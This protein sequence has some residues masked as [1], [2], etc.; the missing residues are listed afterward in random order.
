[1]VSIDPA[2]VMWS[3]PE[4]ERADRPLLVLLHGYGSYEGD[5]FGLSPHLPLSPVIASVR[6]PFAEGNGYSWFPLSGDDRLDVATASAQAVLDW[7]DTLSFTSV[8]LLGFSQGG[9]VSL[10]TLRLAPARF[11][12]VVNL[13]G[14]ALPGALSGD[15]L[16]AASPT[17]VFWG[18]GT[19]DQVIQPAYIEH[20]SSWLP[21]HS[22]LTERIYEDVPHAVSGP[23]LADVSAFIEAQLAE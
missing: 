13:S 19:L 9:A 18:R 23:E 8:G 3:A 10:Q 22:T 12:Y 20:T 16:L 11:S 15:D 5:L 2:A 7:I 14:F 21:S 6:A 17:P 4:R 1:M